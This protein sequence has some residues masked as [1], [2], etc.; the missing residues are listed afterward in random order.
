MVRLPWI[1]FLKKPR[2]RLEKPRIRIPRK[3]PT[4]NQLLILALIYTFVVLSGVMCVVSSIH[5]GTLPEGFLVFGS[6]TQQT[7]IEGI[8]AFG[9]LVIGSI[10]FLLIHHSTKYIYRPE[11]AK[12]L[13]LT[14]IVLVFVGYV[15]LNW[16]MWKKVPRIFG[17]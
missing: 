9:F 3:T 1:K 16:L 5:S 8:I 14:G 15:G 4:V 6:L 2:L 13:L 7:I 17:K 11:Q 10:G 12:T